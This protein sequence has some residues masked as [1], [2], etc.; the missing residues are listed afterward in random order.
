MGV[1]LAMFHS[2]GKFTDDIDVLKMRVSA[3]HIEAL[4]LSSLEGIVYI[5]LAL[6]MLSE[7]SSF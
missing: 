2:L 1:T 5:P 6:L 3:L 4:A 7:L